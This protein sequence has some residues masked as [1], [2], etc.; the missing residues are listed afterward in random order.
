MYPEWNFVS[1]GKDAGWST[2]PSHQMSLCH[3]VARGK[4]GW[5]R[6]P[7]EDGIK[8]ASLIFSSLYYLSM[9]G[10]SLFGVCGEEW[11]WGWAIPGWCS[12]IRGS[13]FRFFISTMEEAAFIIK[14]GS[15]CFDWLWCM[16]WH[17]VSRL[18]STRCTIINDGHI[19]RIHQNIMIN[20][21]VL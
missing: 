8:F 10:N 6:R 12:L 16:W 2:K 19:T 5:E 17:V 14:V 11:G 3:G 18:V 4:G 7:G 1:P 13:Y 9:W 15:S 20:L 21:D